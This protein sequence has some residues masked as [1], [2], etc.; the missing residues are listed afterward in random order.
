MREL[1]R[2]PGW[3]ELARGMEKAKE[4]VMAA[5]MKR[6]IAGDELN[7]RL[8]DFDRGMWH[9][10]EQVLLQPEKAE[11]MLDKTIER[12]VQTRRLLGLVAEEAQT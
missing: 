10:I 9:G 6:L 1:V 3:I 12:I 7:Q 11:E 2:H 4:K 5:H 8:I